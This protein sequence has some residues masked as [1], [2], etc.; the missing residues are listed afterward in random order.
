MPG[1]ESPAHLEVRSAMTH[2][3]DKL[4]VTLT[5]S[6]KA[7]IQTF[8]RGDYFTASEQFESAGREAA[9]PLKGVV[10][11]LHRIA[12]GLHLR[13]ARGGRQATVNLLSHAMMSLDE[14]RPSHAG[15]DVERLYNELSAFTDEIRSSPSEYEAGTLRHKT[16]LFVERRRVPKIILLD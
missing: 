9:E 7:A 8:N 1:R 11:A 2:D 6:L 13:F 12:A 15:I 3:S 4:P 10:E 14:L 5:H 16:R